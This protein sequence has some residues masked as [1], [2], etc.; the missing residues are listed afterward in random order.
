MFFT[1]PIFEQLGPKF[2]RGFS[3]AKTV[4]PK[5]TVRLLEIQEPWSNN[6]LSRKCCSFVKFH[7]RK[8]SALPLKIWGI[9][10]GQVNREINRYMLLLLKFA[11]APT[12]TDL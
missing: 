5:Q 10:V 11:F 12:D 9:E 3:Q 4:C 7:R 2:V 8:N 6:H 1:A